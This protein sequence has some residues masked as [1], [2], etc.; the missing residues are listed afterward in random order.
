MDN[1]IHTSTNKIK[2]I[3]DKLSYFDQYGGTVFLFIIL[4]A[5]VL[6]VNGYCSIMTKAQKIKS[7]WINE[8]CKPQVIPFAGLINKPDDKTITDFTLEN[9][10]YCTQ[11]ILVP[12]TVD[13]ISPFSYIVYGLQAV[14]SGIADSIQEMRQMFNYIRKAFEEIMKE[15][16]GRILNFVIPIQQLI[17]ASIYK[18]KI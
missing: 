17:L 8:R 12:I 18:K 2:K 3:Y 6:F 7:N 14:Y 4:T 1:N 16:F 13:A 10:N 9:F 15:I 5:I 11:Q